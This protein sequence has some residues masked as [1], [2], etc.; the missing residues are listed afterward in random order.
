M[1][2]NPTADRIGRLEQAIS[3]I[4]VG[5][6][7]SP[8]GPATI[9]GKAIKPKNVTAGLIN[10]DDLQSVNSKTGNLSVTGSITMATGGS[11]SS[12]QTAYDTGVGFWLEY[13]AGTPRFSLG[14]SGGSKITWN[15]T[16]LAIT[17]SITAT[18]GA[19]GGWIIGATDL[20]EASGGG[21]VGL[22]SS[23]S[24]RIWV[25]HATPSSAPFRVSSAGVMTTVGAVISSSSSNARV[26]LNPTNGV[27]VYD[28]AGTVR[29]RL[30]TDGSGF[31][32]S[33]DGTSTGAAL[34]WTTAGSA[35]INASAITTGTLNAS[36]IT[37]SNFSASSI[38]AGTLTLG[39][40]GTINTTG[41]ISGTLGGINIAN[42]TVTGTITLGS[43]GSI[44]DADGSYWDQSGLVLRGTG[45]LGDSIAFTRSGYSASG[46][47][48]SAFATN[49][50]QMRIEAFSAASS[51]SA[52]LSLS[53]T[54]V[55][56]TVDASLYTYK[57]GGSEGSSISAFGDGYVRV[58]LGDAAGTN[59]FQVVDS[60]SNEVFGVNSDGDL[61]RPITNDATGLGAY[62]GRVP[63][64]INGTL[65]YLAVYS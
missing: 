64:Y 45:S 21:T 30:L 57:S 4:E 34:R 62:Y 44:V 16:T 6:W 10:V 2:R 60:G 43:G 20:T 11:F 42:L 51:R 38:T 23:G 14:N 25:G 3:D 56:G 8:N 52:A 28:S 18:T 55:D 27:S 59:R 54:N 47:I 39:S 1:A 37:V 35:T 61:V 24:T 29:G 17:G 49:L 13:N 22:A 53:A 36:S 31:L 58:R 40:G 50:G 19:I 12:G 48:Q 63:I 41:S 9:R 15:G 7:R 5:M 26:E 65:K 46:T 32:G 33:T